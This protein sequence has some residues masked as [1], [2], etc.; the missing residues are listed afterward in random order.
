[1]LPNLLTQRIF[2]RS[3]MIKRLALLFLIKLRV[4]SPNSYELLSSFINKRVKSCYKIS[5]LKTR[6]MKIDFHMMWSG[7]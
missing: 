3:E 1:M 6:K 4:T 5:Y 7:K 2:S